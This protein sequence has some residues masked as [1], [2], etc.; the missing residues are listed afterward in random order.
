MK[1]NIF[2]SASDLTSQL[3]FCKVATKIILED[4]EIKS[5]GGAVKFISTDEPL[6]NDLS[7]LF[8]QKIG[9]SPHTVCEAEIKIIQPLLNSYRDVLSY[10]DTDYWKN[11]LEDYI[12]KVNLNL[13]NSV[14]LFITDC[15]YKFCFNLNHADDTNRVFIRINGKDKSKHNK[16]FL[17]IDSF[18]K[19]I[20]NQKYFSISCPNQTNLVE[21]KDIPNPFYKNIK[22]ILNEI[23]N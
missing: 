22:N 23:Y 7:S 8:N 15:N 2:L 14:K 1:K 6:K 19:N 21:S 10:L 3:N 12:E 20:G 11:K 5:S 16:Q 9:I 13:P 18:A 4:E 17:D